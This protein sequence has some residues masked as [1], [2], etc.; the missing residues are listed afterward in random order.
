RDRKAARAAWLE[1]LADFDTPTLIGPPDRLGLGPRDVASFRVPEH[2]TQAITELARS[3]HTTVNTVLQGAFATVLMWL[4]GHHDVAF[5]TV[6]SGRP[7]EV[8]GAESMVGLLINTVPV[9]A[10]ITPATPTAHLL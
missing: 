1:V 7:A 5:G 4:T 9:R 6:V 10:H 3:S 8:T 2:T